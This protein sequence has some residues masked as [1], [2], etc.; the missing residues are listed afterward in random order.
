MS[1]T[2]QAASS[3]FTVQSIINALA[4]FTDVTGVD[5]S[6]N[7]FA[8]AIEHLTSPEAILGLL[9]EREE[10][11]K[12]YRAGNRR[13]T[14][15]LRPAVNVIQAFSGIVGEATLVS[16]TYHPCNFF[17]DLVRSRFHQPRPCSR[18]SI[19]LLLYV[20]RYAFQPTPM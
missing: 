18:G 5:L 20:P 8:A 11:F 2:G 14:G 9:Q 19:L 12:E 17:N 4:D 1:S 10:A 7:S 15:C 16:Y 3:T 13:L 6:K